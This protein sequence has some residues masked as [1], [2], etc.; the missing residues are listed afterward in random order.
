[1]EV[2]VMSM[3]NEHEL[4]IDQQTLVQGWQQALPQFLTPT[5]ECT[6]QADEKHSN[7]LML[8]IK[9]DGRSHYSFDFRVKYVDDREVDVEFLDVEKAGEHV[10][11]QTDIIQSI[12]KDYV[13]NIHECAQSL[14]GLTKH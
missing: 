12:T 8:H 6:I 7:A 10:E 3:A 9:D 5:G 2:I 11:E 1:M 13:R 4:S 14:K